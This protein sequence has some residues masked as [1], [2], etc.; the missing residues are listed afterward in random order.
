MKF[1]PGTEV[2]D[3][4]ASLAMKHFYSHQRVWDDNRE[5]ERRIQFAADEAPGVMKEI[6]DSCELWKG[7]V[8]L[9]E[10]FP[11]IHKE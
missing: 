3:L 11:S 9:E 4:L 1:S 10:W 2:E 6:R 8:N 5:M 7:H